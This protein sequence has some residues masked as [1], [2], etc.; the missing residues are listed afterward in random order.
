MPLS[1]SLV[2]FS[3]YLFSSELRILV[4]DLLAADIPR[5]FL[6]RPPR[7]HTRLKLRLN[8]EHASGLSQQSAL[9]DF[10]AKIVCDNLQ[11]QLPRGRLGTRFRASLVSDQS[12][13]RALGAEVITTNSSARQWR[14][15][16]RHWRAACFMPYHATHILL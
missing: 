14:Q 11:T 2:A 12:H 9:Q 1:S 6:A 15:R 10:H 3:V 5:Q 16:C 4:F 7:L 13:C 8:L